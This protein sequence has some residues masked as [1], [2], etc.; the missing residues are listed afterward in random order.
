MGV[1][2][3]YRPRFPFFRSTCPA[4]GNFLRR[5]AKFC[6]SCNADLRSVK[7]KEKDKLKYTKSDPKEL[8]CPNCQTINEIGTVN[9]ISCGMN[10]IKIEQEKPLNLDVLYK[11]KKSKKE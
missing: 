3:L 11:I 7:Q 1:E 6:P 8:E 10:F 4:C 5:G 9:C 2:R